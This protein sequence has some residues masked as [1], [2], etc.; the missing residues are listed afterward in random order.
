MDQLRKIYANIAKQLSKLNT[1]QKL[2]IGSM[3]VILLMAFFVMIVSFS[4]QDEAKLHDAAGSM[5][6]AF[7]VQP[8]QRPAGIIESSE[9]PR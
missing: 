7:G 5:K 8:V 6:E 9:E 2:L 4:N 1:S 3:A